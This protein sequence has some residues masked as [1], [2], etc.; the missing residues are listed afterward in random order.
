MSWKRC[1][2][3][4]DLQPVTDVRDFSLVLS[5]CGIVGSNLPLVEPHII[6]RAGPPWLLSPPEPELPWFSCLRK[7]K[8]TSICLT[9]GHQVR[10]HCLMLS[11]SVSELLDLTI[12]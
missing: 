5:M 6:R 4:K 11:A 3:S 9:F 8:S 7:V 12:M 2:L 1:V 10:V